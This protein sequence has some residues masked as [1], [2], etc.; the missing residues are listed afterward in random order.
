M[1][2]ALSDGICASV[3]SDLES[4]I[5]DLKTLQSRHGISGTK[6]RSMKQRFLTTGE[7]INTNKKKPTGRKRKLTKEQEQSLRLFLDDHPDSF[8]KEMVKFMEDLYGVRVNESTMQRTCGRIGWKLKQQPR[9]RDDLGF[10]VRTLPRDEE[11]NPIRGITPATKRPADYGTRL[12]YTKRRDLMAKT[13]E[14]VQKYM[15]QPQ[16]DASHDYSHVQRVLALC[17]QLL[18]V[19]QKS[20][21]DRKYDGLVV[22]L[23]ALMHDIDDHKYRRRTADTNTEGYPTPPST[24]GELQFLEAQST[25]PFAP[26]TH[27]QA[28]S[29]PPSY[30][31]N[32]HVSS[33]P[34]V[35]PEMFSQIVETSL[36][37]IGWPPFITAKVAAIVPFISYTG[38][39]FIIQPATTDDLYSL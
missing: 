19:E 21:Q 1:P 20:I 38:E 26:P 5:M 28:T 25:N 14:W 31:A 3:K 15:S 27:S 10:W 12:S 30:D 16:F 2:R 4:G 23:V 29:A 34:S 11:G 6:A 35:V 9:P 18:R 39:F 24:M 37:E 13:R 7:V 17:F 22:E 8:L 32:N 33:A 36:L